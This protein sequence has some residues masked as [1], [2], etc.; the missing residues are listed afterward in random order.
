MLKSTTGVDSLINTKRCSMDFKKITMGDL[1]LFLDIAIRG[2]LREVARFRKVE[3]A[4]LSRTIQRLEK[5]LGKIL[6]ERSAHGLY[7]TSD[8][9]AFRENVQKV[10]GL[11]ETNSLA[12]DTQKGKAIEGIG[13]SSFL[14]N[15]IVLPVVGDLH[16]KKILNTTQIVELPY[17]RLV[18]SGI[19]GIVKL[20][21]HVGLLEWPST[22]TSEKIGDLGWS[23][24]GSR[25]F[26]K[27]TKFTEEEI[28]K[29]HFIYPLHWTP[30]GLREADDNCP[31]SLRQRIKSVG[32]SSGWMA[33]KMLH[34]HRSVSYLPD[35]I[36]DSKDL[37]KLDVKE[38]P[39]MKKPIYLSAQIDAISKKNL[40][41][42]LELSRERLENYK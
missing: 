12:K 30:K 38:W 25:K 7:L 10:L 42:I 19:R 37:V 15:S 27:E 40:Q 20:A 36:V 22:W 2:S 39:K 4:Q 34:A 32:V 28:S 5:N 16:A 26:F 13:A 14:L 9:M 11:M 3:A 18:F 6:F 33:N 21:F 23:L 31:L 35:S 17:D 29:E 24:Y 41:K 1:E 8:G